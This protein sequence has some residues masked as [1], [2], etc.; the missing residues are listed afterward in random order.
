MFGIAGS[1]LAISS[2]VNFMKWVIVALISSTIFQSFRVDGASQAL[3][4][5]A[6]GI[7]AESETKLKQLEE[8]LAVSDIAFDTNMAAAR[9]VLNA[10]GN[11]VGNAGLLAA[12]KALAGISYYTREFKDGGSGATFVLTKMKNVQ[13]D[14]ASVFQNAHECWTRD[15]GCRCFPCAL[16]LSS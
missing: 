16:H 6:I 14:H 2:A 9:D 7:K 1:T 12:S 4:Q 13:S 5:T 8:L 15:T 10:W 11:S 3:K